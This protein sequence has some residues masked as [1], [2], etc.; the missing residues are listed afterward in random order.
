MSQFSRFWPDCEQAG[1]FGLN[2]HRGT[3]SELRIKNAEATPMQIAITECVTQHATSLTPVGDIIAAIR[4]RLPESARPR[5]DEVVGALSEAG[6]RLT[7]AGGCL[8]AA[9]CRLI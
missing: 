5:R 1:D 4:R 7:Y 2:K 9:G 8:H 3:E 6:Y